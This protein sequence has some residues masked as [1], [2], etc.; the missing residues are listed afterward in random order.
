MIQLPIIYVYTQT[1]IQIFHKRQFFEKFNLLLRSKDT[2]YNKH[3]SS[4]LLTMQHPQHPQHPQRTP[5]A[6]SSTLRNFQS[7]KTRLDSFP[8]AIFVCTSFSR[9]SER[10]FDDYS[11]GIV[12]ENGRQIS[13]S[14]CKRKALR[15]QTIVAHDSS[16]TTQSNSRKYLNTQHGKLLCVIQNILRFHQYCNEIQLQQNLEPV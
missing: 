12:V 3:P 9:S 1:C 6:P 2:R 13:F 15:V 16:L 11:S 14:Q 7:D 4:L 8:F 10:P 5:I